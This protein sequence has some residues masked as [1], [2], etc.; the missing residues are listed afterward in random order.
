[1]TTD[2][3][4]WRDFLSKSNEPFSE[5][6]TSFSTLI[7]TRNIIL[8]FDKFDGSFVKVI[9]FTNGLSTIYLKKRRR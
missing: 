4:I 2:L 1:M 5:R 8:C 7:K 6:I 9:D 3:Q